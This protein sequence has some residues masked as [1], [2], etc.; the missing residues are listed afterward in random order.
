[1]FHQHEPT[2]A[3]SR[4]T[5]MLLVLLAVLVALPRFGHTTPDS[6]YYSALTDYFKGDLAREGLTT[7]YVYRW[8]VPW[9]AAWIP[10]VDS[11]TGIALCSVAALVG[12][13]LALHGLL[14][15]L[16]C[17]GRGAI[18]GALAYLVSFPALNYGGAV[19][20][21]STGM[22]VLLLASLALVRGWLWT[23][24]GVMT[25]GAGVRESTLIFL[26]V[27]VLFHGQQCDYRGLARVVPITLVALA[28]AAGSRHYF[29]DLPAYYWTPSWSRFTANMARPISW[30]TVLLTIGP[31]FVL[32]LP[33]LR[34]WRSLPSPVR[35]FVIAVAPPA[36][37]LAAYSTVSAFMGG[38][39]WWPLYLALIPVIA[40]S[41]LSRPPGPG[42]S[43]RG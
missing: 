43:P 37:A 3:S 8:V 39:F 14:C 21:D 6:A 24:L 13:V 33:G 9:F 23:L 5:W 36:L 28:V 17:D 42:G 38:R 26:P 41:A 20:T 1:M 16:G 32:A 7:P 4:P 11:A 22:L 35:R 25:V 2:G 34:R 15:A 31:V 18:R 12:S 29:A 30:A 10:S 27:I 40:A 19:L